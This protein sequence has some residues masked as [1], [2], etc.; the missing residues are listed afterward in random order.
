MAGAHMFICDGFAYTKENTAVKIGPVELW[1]KE[2]ESV[3][4]S[5]WAGIGAI[6]VGGWLLALGGKRWFAVAG[7]RHGH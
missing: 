6:V 5:L 7:A 4:F 3:D 1:L 2:R